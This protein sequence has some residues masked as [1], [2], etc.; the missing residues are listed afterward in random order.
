MVIGWQEGEIEGVVVVTNVGEVLTAW[1]LTAMV[2]VAVSG[3][4]AEVVTSR[5]RADDLG[6]NDGVEGDDEDKGVST[7]GSGSR[8]KGGQPSGEIADSGGVNE[9]GGDENE[10]SD[11]ERSRELPVDELRAIGL[12]AV[13]FL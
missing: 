11:E 3:E 7:D 12:Y 8:G 2:V 4:A 1:L 5:T 10:L 13:L 6:D 9:Y